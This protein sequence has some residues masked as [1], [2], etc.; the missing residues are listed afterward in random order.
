M[1]DLLKINVNDHTERKNGLTYLSW[2][3]AWAEVLKIDPQATWVTHTYGPQGSEEPCMRVGKSAMVHVSVTIK[4]LRRECMLPVM[5]HRNKAIPE[6]DAFQVN[7]AI[8]RCLAKAIAMHGLGL[9]IYAGEDLPE[10]DDKPEPK[11]EAKPG[12]IKATDGIETH[13]TAE[14]R[15]EMDSIAAYMVECHESGKDLDAIRVYYEIE[16]NDCKVYVWKVLAP[17]SKLRSTVKANS[18]RKEAA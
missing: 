3:W 15:Q 11:P 2:A 16:D 5:D 18:P 1:S 17:W 13:L 6:P 9:Y 8:M 12:V 10:N 7:T 14:Q 4:G